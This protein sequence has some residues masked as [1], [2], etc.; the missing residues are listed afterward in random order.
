VHGDR[1]IEAPEVS[2]LAIEITE[3]LRDEIRRHAD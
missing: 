2:A 3:H 1:R